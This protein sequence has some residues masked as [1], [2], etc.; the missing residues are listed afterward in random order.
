MGCGGWALLREQL[1]AVAAPLLLRRGGERQL[2]PA[3]AALRQ[4]VFSNED[5]RR[6]LEQLTHPLIG[7]EILA[8][9]EKSKSPY[10][11]LSSPLLLDTSQKA[12]VDHVVVVDAPE[13]HQLT[14]TMQR[15][16]N[17][18]EQVKRIMAAQM[19]RKD[20][21]ALADTIIDNSGSLQQLDETVEAL[22]RDFLQRVN[23]QG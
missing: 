19:S 2:L 21:L 14:R 23:S 8:Q 15:D 6:W 18:E 17:D 7:T 10:T 4:R 11:L 22:H 1:L 5:E 20:R 16:A 12:L 3:R 13:A 9:I